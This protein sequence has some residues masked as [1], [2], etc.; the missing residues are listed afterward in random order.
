MLATVPTKPTSV[1]TTGQL[2]P[3]G[4]RL[5]RLLLQTAGRGQRLWRGAEDLPAGC[6][7]VNR[8][9][10]SRCIAVFLKQATELRSRNAGERLPSTGSCLLNHK[11]FLKI[12]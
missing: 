8:R 10:G 4:H 11:D 7:H 1:F 6:C 12:F 3:G 5:P 2:R 9:F